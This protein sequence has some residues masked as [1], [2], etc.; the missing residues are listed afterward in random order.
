MHSKLVVRLPQW[1]KKKTRRQLHWGLV[2]T[3]FFFCLKSKQK[4]LFFCCSK[5]RAYAPCVCIKK[6]H[7]TQTFFLQHSTFC[8]VNTPSI[9]RKK[10]VN[11]WT[12]Q[13]STEVVCCCSFSGN[14]SYIDEAGLVTCN[15]GN[16]ENGG[17]P[18]FC[19][20]WSLSEGKTETIQTF[21]GGDQPDKCIGPW[22]LSTS[23][24]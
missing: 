16:H 7:W 3:C 17:Q 6:I 22:S 21:V 1:Q 9:S 2:S 24:I 8:W 4:L 5:E 10:N 11:L 13:Q 18:C 20:V 12:F 14:Q 15:P 23:C 19:G